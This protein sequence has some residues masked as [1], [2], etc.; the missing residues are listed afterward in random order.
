LCF[1][2]QCFL[3]AVHLN[4]IFFK[5]VDPGYHLGDVEIEDFSDSEDMP[6]L[7]L[8][9]PNSCFRKCNEDNIEKGSSMLCDT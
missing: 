9:A 6:L 1:V 2:L 7:K 5:F 4:F 8:K 3:A